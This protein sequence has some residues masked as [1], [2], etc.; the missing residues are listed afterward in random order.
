VTLFC[1][2][3]CVATCKNPRSYRRG[4]YPV[5]SEPEVYSLL[6]G[7][8]DALHS[9]GTNLCSDGLPDTAHICSIICCL[10]FAIT[11]AEL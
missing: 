2:I 7:L 3:P 4:S 11:S 6:I 1:C 8:L 10:L 5:D 9:T